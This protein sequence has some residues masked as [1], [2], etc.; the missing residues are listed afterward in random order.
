MLAPLATVNIDV[1]PADAIG[2]K[3]ARV[4]YRYSLKDVAPWA[5]HQAI[6]AA[7][8]AIPQAVAKPPPRQPRR[9]WY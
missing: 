8:P 9:T 1:E 4:T 5:S 7:L 3:A 2:V 6:A